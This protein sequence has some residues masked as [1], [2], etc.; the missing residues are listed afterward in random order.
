MKSVIV[1]I[2]PAA[3]RLFFS[4]I[5]VVCGVKDKVQYRDGFL[6]LLIGGMGLEVDTRIGK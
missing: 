5:Q 1:L 2:M 3:R 4:E 6:I